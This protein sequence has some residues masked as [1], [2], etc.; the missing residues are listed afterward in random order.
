MIGQPRPE[1]LLRWLKA[2]IALGWKGWALA[3]RRRLTQWAATEG[4]DMNAEAEQHQPPEGQMGIPL[5]T[6][7]NRKYP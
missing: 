5:Q 1:G 6:D 3:N 4:D 7:F 2:F